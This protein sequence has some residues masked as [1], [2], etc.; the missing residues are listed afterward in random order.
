MFF[1]LLLGLSAFLVAGSAAYFSV[2]GIATLFIG[3]YYQVM[4]MAASLEFGKLIATSYLYR[5]WNKTVW[6]LKLYMIIAVL[7]LMGITSMG[8]FGYLSAAYQV[9]SGKFEQITSQMSL[10]AEQKMSTD[11]EIE[12]INTRIEV[13]NKTRLS[14]E[15]RL[16]NLTKSSAAKVYA[17]IEA[18]SKEIKGLTDRIQQLQTGKLEKDQQII[19]LNTEISK[20]KDIGTFKFVA[21][22]INRPLDTI[23]IA[24]ICLLIS[25]F[26][27]LAVALVLAFNVCTSGKLTKNEITD[28]PTDKKQEKSAESSLNKSTNL[29]FIT[30]IIPEQPKVQTEQTP[31]D[32][33]TSSAVS[34]KQSKVIGIGISE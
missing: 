34:P 22:A 17:D 9:N 29:E 3:S 23:V 25:V 18:S 15:Q 33:I 10:I 11:K 20:T 26:D 4:F 21:D 28:E 12:Q 8:I 7:V 1:T 27:P 30:E 14:Q 2:L 32:F 31:S 5:Y 19:A 16:P 13:L 6:W 24:F